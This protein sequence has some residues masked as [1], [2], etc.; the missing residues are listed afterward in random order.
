LSG[1]GQ[2][3]TAAEAA[4]LEKNIRINTLHGLLNS[5]TLNMVGPFT[6]IFAIR[7][8]ATKLHVA[9]LTAAPAIVSLLAMIPG[10]RRVDRQERKQGIT[11]RFM[12]ANR[13]FYLLLAAVPLAPAPVQ[14]TVFVALIAA[15]NLPGAV[16]NVAWQAFISRIIPPERRAAA[17]ARRNR[18]MNIAA[19]AAALLV[20]WFMDR[21]RFPIGYQAAF[22]GAF[23]VALLE[24]RV[25]SRIDETVTPRGV[26]DPR[27]PPLPPSA[28][29]PSLTEPTRLL[30]FLTGAAGRYHRRLLRRI[31]EISGQRRFVRYT[32]I[33]MFFY[34]AWQIPWPLFSW[35]QVRTLHANNLWIS[36]LSLMNTGGALFGYGFWVRMI[37]RKGNIRTLFYATLPIL[38]VPLTYAFSTRLYPIAFFNIAAGAVFSGVNIALFNSLLEVTPEDQKTTYI[39][40]FNTAI[41][42]SSTLAP[43]IGVSLVGLMSFRAAFLLSALLRLAGSLAYLLLNRLEERDAARPPG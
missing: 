5:V 8:G 14:A 15:M 36:I 21:V 30:T 25:F 17:F 10:A 13:V 4:V 33:C 43:L 3:S 1:S 22:A 34:L 39:A 19:T 42:L 27:Q 40:Y 41:T 18:L 7:I 11:R 35:Y 6:A 31:G 29:D 37:Q 9:M 32:L 28:P 26:R 20:G 23:L 16:S 24:L 2:H 38:I 12:L